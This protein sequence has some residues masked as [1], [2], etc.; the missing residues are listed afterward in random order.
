M[1]MHY[2]ILII[3]IAVQSVNKIKKYLLKIYYKLLKKLTFI[4]IVV[5]TNLFCTLK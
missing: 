3:I 2:G 4:S 5:F 1:I